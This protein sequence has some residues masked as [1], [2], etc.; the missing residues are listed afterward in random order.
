MRTGPPASHGINGRAE[1]DLSSVT[2]VCFAADRMFSHK[3]QGEGGDARFGAG[4][5][6]QPTR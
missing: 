2:W 6:N 5:A 4:H 3:R 1:F